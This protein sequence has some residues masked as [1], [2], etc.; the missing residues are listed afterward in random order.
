MG[1]QYLSFLT[2]HVC[3]SSCL[4]NFATSPFKVDR[5]IDCSY[6]AA[7]MLHTIRRKRPT[8]EMKK[9]L[10][11]KEN[12]LQLQSS[13]CFNHLP[14]QVYIEI[15]GGSSGHG[16]GWVDLQGD[17]SSWKKPRLIDR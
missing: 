1:G 6:N 9:P 8:V 13:H 11:D 3:I 2:F 4:R 14:S 10:P 16:L 17:P 12:E 15:Q 7:C 5:S